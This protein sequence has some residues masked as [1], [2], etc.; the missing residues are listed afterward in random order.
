M[1]L[2]AHLNI[3]LRI[4]CVVVVLGDNENGPHLPLESGGNNKRTERV[5]LVVSNH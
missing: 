1:L 3:C 5:S 4:L 2:Y